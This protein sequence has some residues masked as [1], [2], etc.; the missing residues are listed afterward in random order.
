[1]HSRLLEAQETI[2]VKCTTRRP[3]SPTWATAAPT[4]C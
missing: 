2:L 1:M 4:T 3:G